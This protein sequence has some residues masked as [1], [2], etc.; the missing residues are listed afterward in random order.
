MSVCGSYPTSS[1]RRS[2][3]NP[4]SCANDADLED[5]VLI[6][7]T[8]L[9]NRKRFA[10]AVEQGRSLI[11]E[12][13]QKP[14][15]LAVDI[16]RA[17]MRQIKPLSLAE[18]VKAGPH[19]VEVKAATEME[20]AEAPPFVDEVRIE[21]D[22]FATISRL[23]RWKRRLLDLSLRNKLLNFKAGKGSIR[24]I[25]P[26]PALLEDKLA[27][28]EKLRIQA[29]AKVME[30]GDPRNAELNLRFV[31]DDAAKTYAK[32]ALVRGDIHSELD[33]DDLE[34]RL[35]DLFRTARA[36]MEEG[37][38]NSLHLALGFVRWSPT[39]KKGDYR[40][41]LILLPVSL[42]RRT[43]LS[44][45]KL[46]RHDDDARINPT[47]LQM[48]RQDFQ[49]SIPEFEGP[50]LPM[51]ASGLDVKKIWSIARKHLLD[52]KGFEVTED[53]VLSTFSFTKYLMWKDLVDRTDVLKRNPVVA[54]L[55][56]TPTASYVGGG[57]MPD[58]TRL[59][60]EVTSKSLLMPLP[61]DSSQTA[62][63]LA[64]SRG[65]DFVLFGPPG[66]GKSQTIAN[67]IVNTLGE[68]K[69]VLFV[70]Q[71]TTALEV[72]RNRLDK[73][74]IGEFCLEVHSAKAQK[75][76]VLGQL[77]HAWEGRAGEAVAQWEEKADELDQLR[78]SLNDV[79]GALHKRRRNG[80]TAYGAL[81]R[82]IAGRAWHPDLRL[83]FPHLDYHDEAAMRRLRDLCGKLRIALANVGDP[84][85]HPLRRIKKADWSPSWRTDLSEGVRA[86]QL[87][88]S[89][90]KEACA[91]VAELFATAIPE[92][93]EAAVTLLQLCAQALNPEARD[94]LELLGADTSDLG[95]KLERW[96]HCQKKV[97]ETEREL[98]CSY[99]D[100]VYALNLP[101]LL[102]EWREAS[103]ANIL[104]RTG[105]KRKVW[106]ALAPFA[107][108]TQPDDLGIELAALIEFGPCKKA[109]PAT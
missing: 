61:A 40:A 1:R 33:P 100:G 31:G 104:V 95:R 84:A 37:G 62:A 14:F 99:R 27:V 107:G 94:G 54:H 55:I 21:E 83:S 79:V 80:L 7:T 96:I 57:G 74:G 64:A 22:P 81:G 66:T 35:T 67:L 28:G 91:P 82:V 3:T 59:D 89:R 30:G 42:E 9:A 75:S 47:L 60:N 97:E 29:K 25:C 71:K 105:R 73:L 11:E 101:N 4:R 68:G 49:V 46:V 23:E 88:S 52:A 44:G 98:V 26:D 85:S 102:E 6:E 76:A 78:V 56:D 16:K 48:L 17:R 24:L 5:L 19:T 53:V 77:Q 87:A 32:E 36:A 12:G 51:D 109:T 18:D 86:F 72:V 106:Q 63:V 15:E 13:A 10:K 50:E 2:S 38:A 41:P 8:L 108:S 92:R 43:A 70:S 69:T 103:A 58:E 93:P 45:F 65:K 20:L 34:A 39:A 90:Y